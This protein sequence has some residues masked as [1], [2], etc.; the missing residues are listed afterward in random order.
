MIPVS[1]WALCVLVTQMPHPVRYSY[2]ARFCGPYKGSHVRLIV[3]VA[4]KSIDA[5][6]LRERN[7]VSW[8]INMADIRSSELLPNTVGG[9][10]S[11]LAATMKKRIDVPFCD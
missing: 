10:E 7:T 3:S 9:G 5:V 1:S 8:L 4:Y 11:F 2:G 6:L